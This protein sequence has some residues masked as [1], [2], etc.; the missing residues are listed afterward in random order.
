VVD[1]TA[2]G[3]ALAPPVDVRTSPY[4]A[5]EQLDGKR[6]EP[7]SDLFALGAVLYEM[8]AGSKAFPGDT[9]ADLP[10]AIR[11]AQPPPL[12]GVPEGLVRLVSKCLEKSP[13][14]RWQSAQLVLLELKLLRTE[15]RVDAWASK[16]EPRLGTRLE[17]R[18]FPRVLDMVP[19]F[20]PAQTG[21]AGEPPLPLNRA[22]ER[23]PKCGAEDVHPSRPRGSVEESLADLKVR[24]QRCHRCYQRFMR[25]AF[26][27]I[28]RPG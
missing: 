17:G 14:R 24:F 7:R 20:S 1:V 6:D 9:R 2:T 12:A 5:P 18:R 11:E 27:S 16:G 21:E 19:V 26:L 23:C 4:S 22:P 25:V 15:M 28:T 10:T 13:D 8:L 3:V